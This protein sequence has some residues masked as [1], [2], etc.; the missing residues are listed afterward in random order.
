M[1]SVEHSTIKGKAG[2]LGVRRQGPRGEAAKGQLLFLHGAWSSTWYWDMNFMPHFAEA[3]YDCIAVN[4][5]AHGDSEGEIRFAT[6]EN[7][8]DDVSRLIGLLDRPVLIGHSMGG[9][10]AQHIAARQVVRGL[11]LLASVPHYGCWSGFLNVVRTTP[12]GVLRCLWTGDLTPIVTN[13]DAARSLMFSRGPLESDMDYMLDLY[14]VES[15]PALF[16]MLFKRVRGLPA[17]STPRLVVGADRDR[18]V[19]AADVRRTAKRL[20]V[21]PVFISSSSHMLT[22]DHRWRTV[23]AVLMEWLTVHFARPVRGEPVEPAGIVV[24]EEGE[25]E[26]TPALRRA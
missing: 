26:N 10:I 12:S 7:Y 9:F 20:G 23:A 2:S 21:E 14:G 25:A 15:I 1:T 4:L 3:G 5:R 24:S 18:L 13:P 22:V 8:I 16:G 6:I 17:A 11:A 19:S